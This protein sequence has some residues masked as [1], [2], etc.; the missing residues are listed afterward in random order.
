MLVTTGM[1]KDQ[2]SLGLMKSY[3][4]G[5]G[6]PIIQPDEYFL[7]SPDRWIFDAAV[8]KAFDPFTHTMVGGTGFQILRSGFARKFAYADQFV[9]RY[10]GTDVTPDS[11]AI[12]RGSLLSKSQM[13]GIEPSVFN[14][15]LFRKM[16]H[17]KTSDTPPSQYVSVT[18]SEMVA[19]IFGQVHEFKIRRGDLSHAWWNPFGEKEDLAV[20]GTTIINPIKR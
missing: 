17:S 13:Q 12:M 15:N 19:S 8:D 20:G 3:V 18:R 6:F 11:T 2:A 14:R 16:W 9:T 5:L 10:R 7:R 4:T 1:S